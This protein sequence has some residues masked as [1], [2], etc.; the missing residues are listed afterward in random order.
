MA[1]LTMTN[2]H[3]QDK[4]PYIKLG[5][6]GENNASSI[7]I[8]VDEL[9]EGATYY[10][11]IGDANDSG[12]PNTQEMTP[13]AYTNADNENIYVLQM[14]P[15]R[16]WLGHDGIKLLQV[17]CVYTDNDEEV[18]KQS[19]VIHGI[20][21]KNTGFVY[22]YSIAI[23][24]QYIQKIKE[25]VANLPITLSKLKDVAIDTP[26]DGQVLKYDETAQKWVNGEGGG[27][28]GTSNYNALINLPS[29]NGVT[30]KGNKSLTDI[31]IVIP[32]KTSDLTNDSGF[33]TSNDIEEVLE[34]F[35]WTEQT[36]SDDNVTTS[37][38]LSPNVSYIFENRTSDLDFTFSDDFN[39]S[40][41]Q[42]KLIIHT[43][44]TAPTITFPN[45]YG[46]NIESIDPDSTYELICTQLGCYGNKWE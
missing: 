35:V 34:Y 7:N 6:S 13:Y 43:G 37:F 36:I 8:T 19:N 30:L 41:K 14:K 24:E 40:Y 21:T 23:F 28:G 42:C 31:G 20:V 18:C 38:E 27:S 9:I 45:N 10:L 12:L 32:T 25:L 17:R 1:N 33:I 5:S 22:Q 46:V 39:A 3:I 44:E 15:L 16:S 29:I 2:W 26:T 4:T 11:D